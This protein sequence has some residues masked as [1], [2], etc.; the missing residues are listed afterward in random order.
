MNKK[1]L[2]DSGDVKKSPAS[3]HKSPQK[4]I[5]TSMN[6]VEDLSNIQF[7]EKSPIS[8]IKPNIFK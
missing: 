3:K 5:Y 1:Y 4:S 8:P 7:A 6:N 2:N